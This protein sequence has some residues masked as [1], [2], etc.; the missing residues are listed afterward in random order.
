MNRPITSIW[1]ETTLVIHRNCRQNSLK[2]G[3]IGARLPHLWMISRCQ[4]SW[5]TLIIWLESQKTLINNRLKIARVDFS[6]ICSE[7]IQRSLAAI[8]KYHR[9]KANNKAKM[10]WLKNLKIRALVSNKWSSQSPASLKVRYIICPSRTRPD[11]SLTL[12]HW[13]I[14][15]W[16][17]AHMKTHQ[18]LQST[19]SQ[20]N[21]YMKVRWISLL[22]VALQKTSNHQNNQTKNQIDTVSWAK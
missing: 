14:N 6:E 9:R 19:N 16:L 21:N 10:T 5:Q 4:S 1:T 8:L 12:H 15:C 13:T 20:M 18:H 22:R 2:M 17:L 3:K 11:N 7:S